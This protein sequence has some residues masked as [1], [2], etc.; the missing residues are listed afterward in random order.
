MGLYWVKEDASTPRIG[1]DEGDFRD[2]QMA[3]GLLTIA[4]VNR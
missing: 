4:Q 1:A 2:A 3:D